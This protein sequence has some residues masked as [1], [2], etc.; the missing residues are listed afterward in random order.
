M[1]ILGTNWF[2]WGIMS[3]IVFGLTFLVKLPIKAITKHI[4][5]ERARE[6]VNICI[7][8]V[9][10]ALGIFVN[11]L[12]AEFICKVAFT[13][14]NGFKVGCGA[15]TVYAGW[16]KLIKGKVSKETKAVIELGKDIIEDEK[17]DKKDISAIKEFYNKVK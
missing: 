4:K 8:L 12:Y 9:P 10:L 14:T 17:V 2:S 7:M 16:E 3:L 13:L 15:M 1:N 6:L 5:D 11:F